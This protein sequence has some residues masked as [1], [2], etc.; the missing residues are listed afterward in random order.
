MTLKHFLLAVFVVFIWGMNFVVIRVGLN[1]FP[2]LL[3]C[4]VR[5]GLAA[6]PG[7]FFLPKPK[8]SLKYIVGYGLFT[9]AMQFGLLFSGIYLGLSPGLASLV[10]QVQVFF[11]MGL[12]ALIF[13]D[14]ASTWKIV[15]ALISFIGI[16]VV[17]AKLDGGT[18]FIGLSLTLLAAFSWA[19]GN[20]FSKKV[21]ASSP[22]ALV[23]WGSFVAL[24][25][26]IAL[27]LV[28]E[29]PALIQS[30]FQNT[31]PAT[32]GA[33]LY[34]VYLSTHIG[35]GVW[36]FLLNTY[37][38]AVVVPFTL[39]IPVFGFLSSAFFLNE[40]LPSWKIAASLIVLVGLTFNL[41][42]K[43]IRALIS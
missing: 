35:Y 8:A 1:G 27:S 40:E 29:G 39:L 19:A 10:L 38:T 6:F 28:F 33:V 21:D 26:M 5:F 34:L 9:F 15:G 14:R 41:L 2:P 18:S 32:V 25:V 4:A 37:P 22:L 23:V 16:G 20:M 31:S 43:R 30:S 12:A 3:L 11:S 36:G 13:H 17:A 42:E 24:P 7:I